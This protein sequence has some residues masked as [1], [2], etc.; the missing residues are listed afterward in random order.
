MARRDPKEKLRG[1][2]SLR[3]CPRTRVGDFLWSGNRGMSRVMGTLGEEF[4]V[5]AE[6]HDDFAFG[7]RRFQGQAG[8][9]THIDI[10]EHAAGLELVAVP[11]SRR[12]ARVRQ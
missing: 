9:A 3:G 6:G 2:R 5:G 7:G 4:G 8:G 1:P 12:A 11:R 10:M